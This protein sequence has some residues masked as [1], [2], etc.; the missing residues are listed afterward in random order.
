MRLKNARAAVMSHSSAERVVDPRLIH[1]PEHSGKVR[2]GPFH[3]D[4]CQNRGEVPMIHSARMLPNNAS[5]APKTRH[6]QVDEVFGRTAPR[7]CDRAP[8]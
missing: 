2:P 8:L 6:C 4:L 5:V 3:T 7:D 1:E